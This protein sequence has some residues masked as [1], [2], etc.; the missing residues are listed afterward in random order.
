MMMLLQDAADSTHI[1]QLWQCKEI[2]VLFADRRVRFA[3]DVRGRHKVIT[4]RLCRWE[5]GSRNEHGGTVERLL[6]V[7]H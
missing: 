4:A 3:K 1:Q 6:A 2:A 7:V 5:R